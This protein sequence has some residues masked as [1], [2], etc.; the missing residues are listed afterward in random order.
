NSVRALRRKA[1]R[2]IEQAE[3]ARVR[4]M[5]DAVL[6]LRDGP[7]QKVVE[8][9]R[10]CEIEAGKLAPQVAQVEGRGDRALGYALIGA[11]QLAC[12]EIV[13]ALAVF[14]RRKQRRGGCGLL[15]MLGQGGGSKR[16]HYPPREK[17]R[18]LPADSDSFCLPAAAC[19]ACSRSAMMSSACSMP[20][21]RRII[22]GVT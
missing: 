6:H 19:S 1:G 22:S 5:H 15:A 13:P 11:R 8:R 21:L 9:A 7:G 4:H 3:I 10:R 2:R 17:R 20:M 12:Q 16:R 18:C 14:A